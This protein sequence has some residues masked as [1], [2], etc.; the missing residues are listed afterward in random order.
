MK[1][2]K[3]DIK[4]VEVVESLSKNPD[5]V[6]SSSS[7]DEVN[8]M[9]MCDAVLTNVQPGKPL[10]R[11]QVTPEQKIPKPAVLLSCRSRGSV[12]ACPGE[13]GRGHYGN[14]LQRGV[15]NPCWLHFLHVKGLEVIFMCFL[16]NYRDADVSRTSTQ[17]RD[18]TA[19]RRTVSR[20]EQT[21]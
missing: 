9:M 1:T 19:L 14:P 21:L 17:Q 10:N 20:S 7:N 16:Q 6:I 8:A 13:E 11:S 3:T 18:C 15:W 12:G 5:L 2:F 4:R